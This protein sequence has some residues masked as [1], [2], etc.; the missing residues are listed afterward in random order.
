MILTKEIR[1][2]MTEIEVLVD[3]QC[4]LNIVTNCLDKK[5]SAEFSRNQRVISALIKELNIKILEL[6]TSGE[7]GQNLEG[8]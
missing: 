5:I 1:A 7:G 4:D 2:L 8:P 3:K 6:K